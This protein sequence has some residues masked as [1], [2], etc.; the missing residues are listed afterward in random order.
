MQALMMP[1]APASTTPSS[2][3]K[4]FQAVCNPRQLALHD[5]AVG[6]VQSPIALQLGLREMMQR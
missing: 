6:C 5:G 4:L 3:D 1:S 2:P